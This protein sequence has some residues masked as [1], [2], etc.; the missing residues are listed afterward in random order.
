MTLGDRRQALKERVRGFGLELNFKRAAT[1]ERMCDL[2]FGEQ[3]SK[4]KSHRRI[5]DEISSVGRWGSKA[6]GG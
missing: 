4:G 6:S 1:S 3:A 2:S 5:R